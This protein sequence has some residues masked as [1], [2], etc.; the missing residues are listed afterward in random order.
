MFRRLLDGAL[1]AYLRQALM[2]RIRNE[3]G[4][5]FLLSDKDEDRLWECR[6]RSRR[7]T[8]KTAVEMPSLW[9]PKSGSHRELYTLRIRS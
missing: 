5:L 6:L 2:N 3:F 7:A 9:K 4:V 1:Q 8:T